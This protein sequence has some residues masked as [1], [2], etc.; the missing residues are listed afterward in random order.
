MPENRFGD[1]VPEA[2]TNRF[3]DTLQTLTR[4]Q[5]EFAASLSRKGPVGAVLQGMTFGFSDEAAAGIRSLVTRGLSFDEAL[6]VV[7]ASEEQFREESPKTA[8]GL[9]VGG[10]LATGVVGGARAVGSAALRRLPSLARFGIAG[11]AGG[12]ASG[13]GTA[14]GGVAERATGAAIGAP[15]GA[16]L[17]VALPLAGRGAAA[18]FRPI[19]SRLPGGARRRA[20]TQILEALERDEITIEEAQRR[21]RGMGVEATLADV[22]GANVR[23]VGR[24]AQSIPGRGKNQIED[25]LNVRQ[26]G[27]GQRVTRIAQEALGGTDDFSGQLDDLIVQRSQAARPLYEAAYARGVPFTDD[28]QRL[29]N[30]PAIKRAWERAQE[31]AANE[32]IQLPQIFTRDAAGELTLNTR[33]VP[34]MRTIDFIKR[35][36]DDIIERSRNQL[37]GAVEGDLARGVASSRRALL[38]VVDELNPG[39]KAARAAYA[40]SSASIDALRQGRRLANS[41][42]RRGSEEFDPAQIIAE[43][44]RMTDAEKEFFRSGVARGLQDIVEGTPDGADAVKRIIGNELRRNRLRAA[45]PDDESYRAFLARMN[46]EADFFRTRQAV[47]GGSP[48]AR[49]QAEQA[50]LLEGG[51]LA[52][53]ALGR[54]NEAGA[55]I[56][57]GAV[58][59]LTGP[60]PA[61]SEELARILFTPG[62]GGQSILARLAAGP[63]PRDLNPLAVATVLES[64]RQAGALPNR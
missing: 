1:T 15:I 45:F 7:R 46:T 47:L 8:L 44:R 57:R 30:R 4:Q 6:D 55:G 61:V 9:E 28:L 54:F 10:G 3:G 43:L 21:L 25:A 29:F 63:L 31:I 14:E 19:I 35:G 49:I 50:D 59:R 17:G 16:T 52:N 27:Q 40:G 62:A 11:A 38:E 53:V 5:Q 51:T 48:T 23:G 22:G 20:A 42:N 26:E 12:A 34:D 33:T 41:L 64:G 36:L 58:N 18:L 56:V 60:T 37:T 32:D 39:Y 13:A 2:R 24:A